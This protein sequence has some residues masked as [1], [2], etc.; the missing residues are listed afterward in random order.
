MTFWLLTKGTRGAEIANVLALPVAILGALVAMV[1]A[2]VTRS[3]VAP[4]SAGRRRQVGTVTEP[5][6]RRDT[7][8]EADTSGSPTSNGRAMTKELFFTCGAPAPLHDAAAELRCAGYLVK[9]QPRDVDG[10]WW[11]Q[12]YSAASELSDDDL[13]RL[14]EIAEHCGVVFDGWGTYHGPARLDDG[15]GK[16]EAQGT[17]GAPKQPSE[18]GRAFTLFDDVPAADATVIPLPKL[19]T[20]A[21]ARLFVLTVS[22]VP[23]EEIN[24]RNNDGT[25]IYVREGAVLPDGTPVGHYREIWRY[26]TDKEVYR[27]QWI[28]LPEILGPVADLVIYRP[29]DGPTSSPVPYRVTAVLNIL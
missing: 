26:Q 1:A 10:V 7:G 20:H 16:T 3:K 18:R 23:P 12:G 25:Q 19:D 24:N 22:Q 29:Y 14:D 8:L 27:P 13:R 6:E 21:R 5:P 11:L 9:G 2:G 17:L 28:D 4:E 15:P